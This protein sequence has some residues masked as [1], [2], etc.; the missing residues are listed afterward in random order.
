MLYN[1]NEN[2]QEWFNTFSHK[3]TRFCKNLPFIV[4][5]GLFSEYI[6]LEISGF[7]DPHDRHSYKFEIDFNT[8][9]KDYI[10]GLKN[11]LLKHFP[12]ITVEEINW[13]EPTTEEI[14]RYIIEGLSLDEAVEKKKQQ[15]EVYKYRI[16]KIF[17]ARNTLQLYD[18]EQNAPFLVYCN[19]PVTLFISGIE[20]DGILSSDEFQEKL[21]RLRSP[22]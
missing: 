14:S 9:V 12:V 15:K 13:V 2:H 5:F 17:N 8:P 20:I 11:D 10:A 6:R 21:E 4:G 7:R 1:L 16:E 3:F 22:E 18:F 19:M